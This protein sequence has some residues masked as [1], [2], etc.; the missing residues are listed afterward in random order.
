MN[1]LRFRVTSLFTKLVIKP[2]VRKSTN[3]VSMRASFEAHARR[4]HIHPP[5]AV[6][7]N[8]VLNDVPV[9]WVECDEVQ[10]DD[11]LMYV[12]GGGFIVG[13]P[14]THKHMVAYLAKKLKMEAVMPRYRL[15]PEHPFPAGFDDVVAT[16]NGLLAQ[17]YRAQQ[18]VLAGDSAGGNLI[19]ALLAHLSDKGMEMPQSAVA[20]SPV[21]DIAA[22]FESMTSN[23]N[24]DVLLIADR[25]DELGGMYLNGGDRTQPYASPFRAKFENC[26]PIMFH[27]CD[28]E[29][30]RDDTIEMQSKLAALGHDVLVRSWPNS[31]HVFHIMYGH[32]PEARIALND[33]VDFIKAKRKPNDN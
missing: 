22:S 33:V 32:F 19:L 17:G 14:N 10:S 31:F 18:I 23:A 6:Y 12:H 1:S 3:P 11:I 8:G 2:W 24:T 9:Q 4:L 29:V 20:L 30:L 27:C 25:F 26:P 16:Y 15:A 21:V 28:G 7:R 13:S 5:F